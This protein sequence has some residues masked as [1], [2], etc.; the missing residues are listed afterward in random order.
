M[1]AVGEMGW[2]RGGDAL[3]RVLRWTRRGGLVGVYIALVRRRVD[4]RRAVA[5]VENFI[6]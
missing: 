6:F 4:E 1:L 3:R 5:T 2:E